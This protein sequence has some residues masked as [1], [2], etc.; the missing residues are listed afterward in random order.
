LIDSVNS[1]WTPILTSVANS[2]TIDESIVKVVVN[3]VSCV[4]PSTFS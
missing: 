4:F 2:E 3:G 1:L